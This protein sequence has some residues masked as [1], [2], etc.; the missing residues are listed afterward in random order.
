MLVTLDQAR[1]HLRSDTDADDAD[2]RLKIQAAS[3]AVLDYLGGYSASFTDSSGNVLTDSDGAP[4]GVPERVQQ[5]TLM[6]VAYLYRE[7]DG[8]QK[9][10]VPAQFGYGYAL[11]QGV[12]ALLYSLRKPTVA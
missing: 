5:A 7:R 10:A 8:S 6:M 9:Y 2:L 12:T 11:P 3:A 4:I 1:E